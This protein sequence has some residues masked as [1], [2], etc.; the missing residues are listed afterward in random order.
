MA[1]MDSQTD[2]ALAPGAETPVVDETDGFNFDELPQMDEMAFLPSST[3]EAGGVAGSFEDL[4][5]KGPIQGG[6]RQRIADIAKTAIGIPY[7]WGGTD[8]K[9]GVDCSGFVQQVYAQMGIKLPRVSAAQARAGR[10]VG[11]G[12]LQVGDL[13][14][15]DNSSRNSGADHIAI[16]IGNGQII[17]APRPGLS[18][19]VRSLGK[20][21]G[22]AWGVR[23]D[24]LDF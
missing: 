21:E 2:G 6:A 18:V 15:W 13:V 4:F 23:L 14:G 24:A 10:R 16:Y 9:S 19:R 1:E 3:G 8:L 7:T 12:E 17:E 20:D 5:P 11:L 22:D